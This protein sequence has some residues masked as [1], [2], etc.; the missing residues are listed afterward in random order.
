MPGNIDGTTGKR[1]DIIGFEPRW[2][3][4]QRFQGRAKKGYESGE[5]GNRRL[6]PIYYLPDL[7][8]RA[9]VGR[10]HTECTIYE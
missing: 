3:E 2:K 6:Q 9:V 10:R 4:I 7:R 8:E 1:G 5:V